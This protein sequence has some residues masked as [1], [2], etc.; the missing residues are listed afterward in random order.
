MDSTLQRLRAVC[1]AAAARLL[2]SLLKYHCPESM[3]ISLKYP[4]TSGIKAAL[5]VR[6]V[7][8]LFV[9]ICLELM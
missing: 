2:F 1:A 7:V 4:N 9:S 3:E 6:L 8:Y 5:F